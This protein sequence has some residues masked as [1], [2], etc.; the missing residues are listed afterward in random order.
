MANYTTMHMGGAAAHFGAAQER[1]QVEQAV[2]WAKSQ[3]LPVNVLGE[4]SNMIVGDGSVQ[5]LIL[6]LE[7]AGF[8]TQPLGDG[9]VRVTVGGGEHWDDVVKRTV[10]LGL[11][12]L[13]TLSMIPGTTGAAPVQNAGAYGGE[14]AD[15]LVDVEAYDMRDR[16]WVTLT[17]KDCDLDYRSSRFREADAGR[18]IITSVRFDLREG[19]PDPA[20]YER[21]V[22]RLTADGITQPT[23]QQLRDTVMALRAK[24][25][26]DPSVVPSAGSF[27]KNPIVDAST[28]QRLVHEFPEIKSFEY[29]PLGGKAQLGLRNSHDK[30]VLGQSSAV[31]E[32]SPAESDIKLYK[33][34]AGWLLEQCEFKGSEHFGL[35]IWPEHALVITNPDHRGYGDLMKLVELMQSRVDDKFGVKLEPEPLFVR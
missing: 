11:T 34:A 20:R 33:L 8:M 19:V 16:A 32:S 31:A 17:A 6:K 2:A 27:F 18:F 3:N 35:K 12:G 4:G 24:V 29:V 1:E 5:A 22:K 7:I 21:L 30:V 9:L 15:H 28:L 25:L 14:I 26:P 13:E 10:D 23:G